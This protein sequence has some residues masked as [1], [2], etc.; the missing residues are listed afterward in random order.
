ML[1]T[2]RKVP[3]VQDPHIVIACIRACVWAHVE[4]RPFSHLHRA[5]RGPFEPGRATLRTPEVMV[6]RATTPD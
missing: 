5:V 2:M 1:I 4:G 6:E 3:Q